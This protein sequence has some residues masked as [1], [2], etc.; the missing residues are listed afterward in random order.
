MAENGTDRTVSSL[1]F[2][3]A[4]GATPDS[5]LISLLRER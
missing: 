1:T 5:V 4:L 3:V 2:M